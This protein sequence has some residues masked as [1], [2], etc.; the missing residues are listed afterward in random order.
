MANNTPS[1]PSLWGAAKTT[2]ISCLS[3]VTKVA[4]GTE[5]FAGAYH[6]LGKTA[7]TAGKCMRAQYLVD[8]KETLDELRN[9]NLDEIDL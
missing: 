2:V 8:N 7:E 6:E 1:T 5:A 3:V 9:T 4:Q